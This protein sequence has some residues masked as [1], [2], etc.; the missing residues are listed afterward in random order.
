ME[1]K[2]DIISMSFGYK[3]ANDDVEQ[4]I[5]DAHH[6][7]I[8]MFAATSNDGQNGDCLYPARQLEVIDISSATAMGS[9]SD[10][11]PPS[12]EDRCRFTCLGEDIALEAMKKDDICLIERG[13]ISGASFATPFAVGIA[14]MVLGFV[15][16]HENQ[17]GRGMLFTK[18]HDTSRMRR[19][20]EKMSTLQNDGSHWLTPWKFFRIDPD[21]S[22]ET[23]SEFWYHEIKTLIR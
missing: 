19:V 2:V 22:F 12:T 3:D 13:R 7:K 5:G 17:T 21:L 15:A 18:L 6:K 23:Q 20:L 8:L 9:S 10:S 1:Q 4:A 11:N 14:A 16:Q